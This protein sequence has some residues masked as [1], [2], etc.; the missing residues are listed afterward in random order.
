VL[1]AWAV[2]IALSVVVGLTSLLGFVAEARADAAS[3]FFIGAG[4]ANLQAAGQDAAQPLQLQLD[5]GMGT[6]PQNFLSFGGLLRSNTF[7][8]EGTDLALLQRTA[9]RGYAQGGYGLALDVGAYQRWWGPEST[10]L[11]VSLNLGAPW[12]IGLGLNGG[13]GTNSATT[14][15]LVLGLDW[16]R[17]TSHRRSG[18]TWWPS[19]PLPVPGEDHAFAR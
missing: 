17:L 4:G 19:Y 18:Q 5:L 11:A 2:K 8:A 6:S 10:G 13:F 1:A 3:W 15:G 14:V 7:F 9:T 12:G 16:A